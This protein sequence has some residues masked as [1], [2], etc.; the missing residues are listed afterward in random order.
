[1]LSYRTKCMTNTVIMGSKHFNLCVLAVVQLEEFIMGLSGFVWIVYHTENDEFWPPS[2]RRAK[3]SVEYFENVWSGRL[4]LDPPPPYEWPLS[5]IDYVWLYEQDV[6]SKSVHTYPF[7]A[8][9]T[10]ALCDNLTVTQNDI[11]QKS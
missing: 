9:F 8:S 2:P 11:L 7:N 10:F 6:E 4:L 5:K 3:M 1:M